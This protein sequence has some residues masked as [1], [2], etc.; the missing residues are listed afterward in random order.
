MQVFP[1]PDQYVANPHFYDYIHRLEFK[2]DGSIEMV[3]GG[4]QEIYAVTHGKYHVTAIDSVS[5]V[6]DF[7]N[8][9]M[10]NPFNRD[11][12]VGNID[13]FQVMA[14]RE[15]GIFPFRIDIVWAIESED[16]WP[17]LLYRSRFIFDIDPM[18]F[19]RPDFMSDIYTNPVKMGL[20]DSERYYYAGNERQNL[21]AHEL[22]KLGIP[23]NA[24]L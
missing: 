3:D 16:V 21:T 19:C 12:K 6:V 23:Q 11:E 18:E 1:V 13:D 9:T 8:I 14:T 7:Y 17:C 10:I 20:A 2:V 15:D 4:G 5:T 22:E 24:F